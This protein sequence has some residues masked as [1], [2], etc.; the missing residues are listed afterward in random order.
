MGNWIGV[1]LDGTLARHD[2]KPD[3]PIG[4]PLP[5]MLRRVRQWLDDGLEVRIFTARADSALERVKISRWL[6]DNG[7][8][9]L[10]ITNKKDWQMQELWDDRAIRVEHNE[11]EPCPGCAKQAKF[12]DHQYLADF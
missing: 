2:G 1:D 3:S 4:K 12:T 10:A 11:G 7:L 6:E 8:P 5:K 9:A